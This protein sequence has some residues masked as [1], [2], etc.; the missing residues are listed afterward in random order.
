MAICPL[1][2]GGG[3]RIKILDALA[4]GMPIVST[5]IGCEGID[6]VPDRDV[7]IA[8]TPEAFAGRSDASSTT[9]RCARLA[10]RPPLAEAAT[11]GPSWPPASPASTKGWPPGRR[12]PSA[13][14]GA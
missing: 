10:R 4:K 7:L 6:V 9:R 13:P 11:R 14:G 8:D 2:D 5:R 3:T 12:R 1:R